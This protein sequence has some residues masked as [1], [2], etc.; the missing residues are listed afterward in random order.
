MKSLNFP[1]S[2]FKQAF[3][4]H[5]I[6]ILTHAASALAWLTPSEWV[7]R[8]GFIMPSDFG[9][10]LGIMTIFI[11]TFYVLLAI[12]YYL[13]RQAAKEGLH[14]IW[15]NFPRL[16]DELP[17]YFLSLLSLIGVIA[18]YSDIIFNLGFNGAISA[19][20]S[21]SANHLK[22]ALY[23][24]YAIGL[25]SLR[26]T[27]ILAAAIALFR[28]GSKRRSSYLDAFNL[29]LLILTTLIASRLSFIAA[30]FSSICLLVLNNNKFRVRPIRIITLAL[31][32]WF[33]LM[34]FNYSRN[35][36]YYEN[37]GANNMNT[38]LI[39]EAVSYLGAPFQGS[40][41]ALDKLDSLWGN[42]SFLY[43]DG[44]IE[45]SL[46]TNSAIAELI[47]QV[48]LIGALFAALFL[49][50]FCFFLGSM[51]GQYNNYTVLLYSISLY[52]FAE[53]WRIFMFNKGIFITL[54]VS[55]IFS[56]FCSLLLRSVLPSRKTRL[57][58]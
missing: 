48:G 35:Y 34:L 4:P 37:L 44:A 15:R 22:A 43:A 9:R 5:N 36:L 16:E 54:Y 57:T 47:T 27:S 18:A 29:I 50:V 21:S 32:F 6:F 56:C 11:L 49:L 1:I 14:K 10:Y 30:I 38:A 20:Q 42:S 41:T 51:A 3:T 8:K 53:L 28:I 7:I 2:M 39:G 31:L 55:L 12:S 19:I 46:T 26:Y 13:G 58:A 24:D 40:G 23:Q 25:Q 45:Q 33:A 52:G 17:Y